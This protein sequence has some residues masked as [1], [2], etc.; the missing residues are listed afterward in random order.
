MLAY[1]PST[2]RADILYACHD[3][4]MAAHVGFHRTYEIIESRYYWPQMLSYL[5]KYVKIC[6]VC[7]R[8]N[9][10]NIP[11]KGYLQQIKKYDMLD[12][13]SCDYLGPFHE[14]KDGYR[15]LL[16]AVQNVSRFFVAKPVESTGA[17]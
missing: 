9:P 1:I 13:W 4:K 15:Y 16:V 11:P 5:R 17:N 14:T 10:L 12:C 2:M 7:Q 8:R 3:S 6:P